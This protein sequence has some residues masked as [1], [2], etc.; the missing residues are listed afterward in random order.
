LSA[1]EPPELTIFSLKVGLFC[2]FRK[3]DY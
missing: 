1:F 3:D 2:D